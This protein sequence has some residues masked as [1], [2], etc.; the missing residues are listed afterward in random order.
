MGVLLYAV[1]K[2][3]GGTSLLVS[4]ALHQRI[5]VFRLVSTPS[6]LQSQSKIATATPEKKIKCNMYRYDGLYKVISCAAPACLD[7]DGT[8]LFILQMD[9]WDSKLQANVDPSVDTYERMTVGQQ[10]NQECLHD[11]YSLAYF[12]C[13]APS[14]QFKLRTDVLDNALPLRSVVSPI[15]HEESGATSIPK[16]KESEIEGIDRNELNMLKNTLKD[17]LDDIFP[18]DELEAF[19]QELDARREE[20]EKKARERKLLGITS[21]KKKKTYSKKGHRGKMGRRGI[22]T[23]SKFGQASSFN[24]QL[25]RVLGTVEL[26]QA[27]EIMIRSAVQDARSR[28]YCPALS[29]AFASKAKVKR[30]SICER[31]QQGAH[32]CRIRHRHSGPDF[33]GGDS[34]PYLRYCFSLPDDEL[35]DLIEK[36]RTLITQL[37]GKSQS[38]NESNDTTMKSYRSDAKEAPT[39]EATNALKTAYEDS[40]CERTTD[41]R[42]TS[43]SGPGRESESASFSTSFPSPVNETN[44]KPSLFI[45]EPQRDRSIALSPISQLAKERT[46]CA[47][48]TLKRQKTHCTKAAALHAPNDTEYI[49]LDSSSSKDDEVPKMSIPLSGAEADGP[50][51]K[52]RRTE[53]SCRLKSTKEAATQR[54]ISRLSKAYVMSLGQLGFAK[55]GKQYLPT[56]V[57]N[58]F[59][60]GKEQ[61]E[62]WEK[63]GELC[64]NRL[65]CHATVLTV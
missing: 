15:E 11:F 42:Q 6:S 3:I 14:L 22:V 49:S 54:G 60:E 25:L 10:Q 19:R 44:A 59:T 40:T 48:G 45:E 35:N 4:A 65:K 9:N 43:T 13:A 61:R 51:P 12:D 37:C 24:I 34:A 21:L 16:S 32:F 18:Q 50:S 38:E 1:E 41:K 53:N 55:W 36:D 7:D 20:E 23:S 33:D 46:S 5:R 63:V 8:L 26:A 64:R 62:E 27:Q 17:Q 29:R 39:I 47:N 30:C 52:K 58:P 28:T 56:R 31:R 2:R 57:V